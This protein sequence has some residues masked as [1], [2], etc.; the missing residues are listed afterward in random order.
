MI[1]DNLK[2]TLFPYGTKNPLS[3]ITISVWVG[4]DGWVMTEEFMQAS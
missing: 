2:I 3:P 4:N 1:F